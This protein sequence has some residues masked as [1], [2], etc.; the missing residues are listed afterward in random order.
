[1]RGGWWCCKASYRFGSQEINV[2]HAD[3][4][5][6]TDLDGRIFLAQP[7]S[8]SIARLSIDYDQLVEVPPVVNFSETQEISL[9]ATYLLKTS[10][11][12]KD[13]EF[14]YAKL[15]ILSIN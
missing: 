6:F 4:L 2:E 14:H 9:D 10:A 13:Q 7:Q 12:L 5:A 3:V 15:K 11:L 1:M 8:M